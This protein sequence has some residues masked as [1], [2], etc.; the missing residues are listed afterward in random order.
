M[1]SLHIGDVV[2]NFSADTTHGKIKFHEWQAGKWVVLF[3]HPADFTPVCTTELG[4]I[5]VHQPHFDKR[6]VKLLAH[7]VD[8]LKSHKDWVGFFQV[9]D[10]KNY[11]KDIPGEFPYPIISDPDRELAVQLDMIDAKFQKSDAHAGTIRALYIIDPKHI[12]RLSMH[13]PQSTGR[14]VE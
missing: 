9:N 14:N 2:P 6:N 8:D 4:R 13:Y 11:C 12:L 3:S 5:A 10:I 1:P 7:S